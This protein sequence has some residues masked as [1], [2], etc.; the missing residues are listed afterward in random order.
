MWSAPPHTHLLE[1]TWPRCPGRVSL[2]RRTS[3]HLDV[4]AAARRVCVCTS[5]STRWAHSLGR[6]GLGGDRHEIVQLAEV[7]RALQP[8]FEVCLQRALQLLLER[9][10]G[11]KRLHLRPKVVES[12]GGAPQRRSILGRQLTHRHRTL[13]LRRVG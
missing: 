12:S 8:L 11:V 13:A 6:V 1:T 5:G 10:R 9:C 4:V 3:T 2:S 7:A